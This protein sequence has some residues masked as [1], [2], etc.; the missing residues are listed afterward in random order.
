MDKILITEAVNPENITLVSTDEG[1]SV[2]LIENTTES[3][4]VMEIT[5]PVLIPGIKGDTGDQGIPGIP[6]TTDHHLLTNLNLDDHPQYV[7]KS[8]DIMLGA[9]QLAN[10]V[11]AIKSGDYP[12]YIKSNATMGTGSGVGMVFDS[13]NAISEE[14]DKLFAINSGGSEKINYRTYYDYNDGTH[15]EGLLVKSRMAVGKNS[16]VDQTAIINVVDT[17]VPNTVTMANPGGA[18]NVETTINF[19]S[20]LGGMAAFKI[21]AIATGNGMLP[22][23]SGQIAIVTQSSAGSWGAN[24]NAE[25]PAV[26]KGQFKS[27]AGASL[28]GN[29]ISVFQSKKPVFAVG[30]T[31]RN[32]DGVYNG[33][34]AQ[35][36]NGTVAGKLWAKSYGFYAHPQLGTIEGAGIY[37]EGISIENW[38]SSHYGIVLNGNTPT[39]SIVFGTARSAVMYYNGTN[40]IINPKKA[41]SGKVQV[42]GSI[43]IDNQIFIGGSGSGVLGGTGMSGQAVI[44]VDNANPLKVCF[45]T[46]R[47]ENTTA[48]LGSQWLGGRQRGTLASPATIVSGDNLLT[49]NFYAYD[50]IDYTISS[51][52][53]ADCEGTIANNQVPGKLT[54]KTAN[55]SG[56]LTERLKIDSAGNITQ[57]TGLYNPPQYSTAEAPAYTKGGVYFDTTLN[58]LRVGGATDWETIT[59]A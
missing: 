55:S 51:Q 45:A 50:G 21:N 31:P 9:L 24:L 35:S 3:P 37:I 15:F 19:N 20:M 52:I 59:S 11:D 44:D 8:G 7:K 13:A 18:V 32:Y 29:F 26:Y 17:V 14:G 22:F 16:A 48:T 43:I 30:V 41:G 54:F 56:A 5:N 58:K 40:F 38:H 28:L 12:V 49:Q 6:G 25:S 39:D 4:L 27:T 47:S 10:Q 33:F 53:V 42:T 36:A 1:F 46:R 34:E 57:S 2:Q 23:P